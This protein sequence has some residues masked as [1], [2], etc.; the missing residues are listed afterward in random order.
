MPHL[1][2]ESPGLNPLVETLLGGALGLS[3]HKSSPAVSYWT[4]QKGT[5]TLFICCSLLVAAVFELKVR[6]SWIS[7]EVDAE[8]KFV[9]SIAPQMV[10]LLT[11]N[12]HQKSYFYAN[13]ISASMHSSITRWEHWITLWRNNS[14]IQRLSKSLCSPR[15]EFMPFLRVFFL[16]LLN[17][18]T[19]QIN[20][21]VID[22]W[23]KGK[24]INL[25]AWL[26][27]LPS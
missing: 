11:P 23:A 22:I 17:A 14:F 25:A 6:K 20:I 13:N 26:G 27:F 8:P 1:R 18:T 4:L 19:K 24:F 16:N 15:L 9:H 3:P 21:V 5:F 12:I 7:D 2:G 10:T